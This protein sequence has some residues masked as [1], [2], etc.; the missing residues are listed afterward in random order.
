MYFYLEK[1]VKTIILVIIYESNGVTIVPDFDQKLDNVL[2]LYVTQM[3]V[4]YD[5]HQN[6][7]YILLVQLQHCLHLLPTI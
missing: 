7:C 3:M 6:L 1:N 5:S 4:L 2:T